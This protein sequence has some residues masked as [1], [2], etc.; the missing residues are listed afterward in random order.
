LLGKILTDLTFDGKT[1]H[2]ISNFKI[3]RPGVLKTDFGKL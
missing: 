3:T 1:P 2:N